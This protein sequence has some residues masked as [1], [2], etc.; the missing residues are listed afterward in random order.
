MTASDIAAFLSTQY[1]QDE[2]LARH[3]AHIA[4]AAGTR[5][6]VG[7]VRYVE[8]YAFVSICTPLPNAIEIA[9]AGFDGTGGVHGVVYAEHIAR[10]NP[11]R[12]LADIA[13]KRKLLALWQRADNAT[14][15]PDMHQLA[16][17]LL[18]Q[19]LAPY[20]KRAV[21]MA[22]DSMETAGWQLEDVEG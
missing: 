7:P 8:D 18:E 2:T 3:A 17:D 14:G 19:L 4:Q 16:D 10:H 13:A 9:G 5:W 22:T 12:V 6:I 15:S 11:A 20:G 21:W 1:D